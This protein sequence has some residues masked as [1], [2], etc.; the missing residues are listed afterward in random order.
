MEAGERILERARTWIGTPYK[1]AGRDRR[2]GVD[3]LNYVGLSYV[4]AG[5]LSRLPEHRDYAP[6][7]WRKP[8]D[9][10]L[11]A[12]E[13]GLES[14]VAPYESTHF[15]DT[16]RALWRPGDLLCVSQLRRLEKITHTALVERVEPHAVTILHARQGRGGKVERTQ[17]CPSWR[18][19]RVYRIL[20][21][22]A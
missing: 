1:K 18:V 6:G 19:L 5:I 20:G 8:G 14:I 9:T 12:I 3:C 16:D 4:E 15:C 7:F 10:I 11:E 13:E 17:L 22:V 21:W 2:R